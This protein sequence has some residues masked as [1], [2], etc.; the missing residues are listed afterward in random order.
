MQIATLLIDR[1]SY[2][3]ELTSRR[4]FKTTVGDVEL[5]A[6]T[7]DELEQKVRKTLQRQKVEYQIPVVL[8]LEKNR[9]NRDTTSYVRA[10]LRGRNER[11]RAFLLTID[12]K[13]EAMDHPRIVALGDK[14]TDEELTELNRLSALRREAG[15]A[16]STYLAALP[17]A[18]GCVGWDVAHRLLRE[19][20]A[21]PSSGP[22][23]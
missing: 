4:T 5:E 12:G 23:S 2:P 21:M 17:A 19:A 11:T 3:V 10:M 9:E 8:F 13:K 14:L 18:K 20:E 6:T 7:W 15:R 16:E 22:H 1:T